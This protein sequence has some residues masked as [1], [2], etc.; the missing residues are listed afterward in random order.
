MVYLKDLRKQVREAAVRLAE[1]EDALAKQCKVL[2][3]SIDVNKTGKINVKEYLD[4]LV[5][6]DDNLDDIEKYLN[7]FKQID[8]DNDEMLTLEEIIKFQYELIDFH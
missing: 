7:K 2:F 8:Q 6:D 4:S 3:D 5:K 1:A